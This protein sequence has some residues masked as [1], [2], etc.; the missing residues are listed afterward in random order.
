MRWKRTSP[1]ERQF[2]SVSLRYLFCCGERHDLR[3]SGDRPQSLNVSDEQGTT[4][5][6]G[7]SLSEIGPAPK[8]SVEAQ[9]EMNDTISYEVKM[10]SWRTGLSYELLRRSERLQP[11]RSAI[12]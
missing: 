11:A 3:P 8:A 10:S 9:V 1:H 7:A 12:E 2:E 4:K 6:I 5:T